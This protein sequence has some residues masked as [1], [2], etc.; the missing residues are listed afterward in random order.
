MDS[1]E[2][3]FPV[4]RNSSVVDSVKDWI[5]DQMIKGN[6]RPGSK[7]PTE[8]ELSQR[9]GVGR[10]SV[11][12]AI[13]QMEAY[14]VLYIKR[15]EGTFVAE[16]FDPKM[17][18]PIFYSIILQNAS[19]QDFVDL[20][21]AI[22]IGTLYVLIGR[23]PKKEELGRLR[24]ALQNLE[25]AVSAKKLD[26]Q[27][28]TEADC[29]FHNEIIS[30]TENPQLKTLSEYINRITVPSR[31]KTTEIVIANGEIDKY[32]HLHQELYQIVCEGNREAIEQA[33]LN[34]Y[35]FWEKTN[36]V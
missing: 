36:Q 10:N 16:Q 8:A 4:I 13:K 11:R 21:R 29:V 31:E 33:V 30:L 14:G 9:L 35:V 25:K 19:W 27:K 22:D 12:E 20:R 7:L 32:V 28:I 23:G 34:H 6:L 26:V 2:L 24:A 5:T 3:E 15:A 1:N 18:S 17:L